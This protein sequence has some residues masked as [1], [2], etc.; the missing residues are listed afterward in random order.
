MRIA[1]LILVALAVPVAGFAQNTWYV[2]DSN[3]TGPWLG[4]KVYPFKCI[5]LDPDLAIDGGIEHSDNGDTVIVM[6]GTYIENVDF[7]GMG[8]KVISDQGAAVTFIDGNQSGSTVVFKTGEGS[9]SVLEGFTVFNG[10]ANYGG[11]IYC[12]GTTPVIKSNIIGLNASNYDGGGIC[13]YKASPEITN[14][15]IQLNSSN[16]GSGY[17]G[18]GI[19]CTDSSHAVIKNNLIDENNAKN[20][21]GAIFCYRSS[22]A[23]IEGN[24]LS[25]NTTKNGGAIYTGKSSIPMVLGNTISDNIASV[26]GGGI[27]CA[28]SSSSVIARNSF[29]NN[30]SNGGSGQGGGGI[31]CAGCSPTIE[32]N[33][34]MHNSAANAGGAIFCYPGSPKIMNNTI[35]YNSSKNGG[36]IYCNSSSTPPITNTIFWG[37][38]A[39]NN[40]ELCLVSSNTVVSYCN[41]KG[42]WPGE[43]NLSGSDLDD[44]KLDPAGHLLW[45]SPCINRGTFDNAPLD[46]MDGEARP[47]MG[48]A[49]QLFSFDI[50]ADEYSAHLPFEADAFTVSE[51]TGGTINYTLDAGP[52]NAGNFYL[53]FGTL[54]GTTPG[55]VLPH[56]KVIL[57]I[58]WDLFTTEF[59]NIV[60]LLDGFMGTLD[61]NGQASAQLTLSPLPGYAGAFLNFAFSTFN[62]FDFT[63]NPLNLEIVP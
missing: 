19:S 21:G 29:M 34:F 61:G 56:N 6:P 38:T 12:S 49:T 18:G 40:A 17:G 8:V 42:G 44:P 47:C 3:T 23:T 14:N 5:G 31:I 52:A 4:S 57:P 11:G 59:L 9:D 2:D 43:G 26:S 58:N 32:N 28:S 51:T 62:P 54:S 53:I 1:I 24:T 10:K 45:D 50:G 33:V 7:K 37:N 63:S 35:C 39:P 15:V 60:H 46:D 30:S 41:V 13:C 27:Y 48:L 22:H 20:V 55:T 36:G 25:K 16:G